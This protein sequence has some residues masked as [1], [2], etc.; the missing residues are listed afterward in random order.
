MLSSRSRGPCR[1]C[2][3]SASRSRRRAAGFGAGAGARAAH[4][5]AFEIQTSSADAVRSASDEDRFRSRA[6]TT[7]TTHAPSRARVRSPE[8][9]ERYF[10]VI[11][12]SD[13]FRDAKTPLARHRLVNAALAE[14]LEG[15]DGGAVH[16]LTVV[17]KTPE[18][19]RKMVETGKVEPGPSS[20]C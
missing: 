15:P 9:E 11:V 17:A 10:K 1:T 16:A 7:T 14:E 5:S 3:T 4:R 18:Q 12:V 8:E 13:T 20:A 2:W 6:S 19:W